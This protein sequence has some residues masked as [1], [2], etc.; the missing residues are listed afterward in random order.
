[1]ARLWLAREITGTRLVSSP[2]E[3]AVERPTSL[4]ST[5]EW[6]KYSIGLRGLRISFKNGTIRQQNKDH[7]LGF[8]KTTVRYYIFFFG[9]FKLDILGIL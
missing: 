2:G 8:S 9:Y 5:P 1:M 3:L 6:P 7:S 4:E